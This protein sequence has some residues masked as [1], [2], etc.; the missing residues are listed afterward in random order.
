[1][2][3]TELADVARRSGLNVIETPGWKTRGHG[4]MAGVKTIICHHTA[5]PKTGEMPSLNTV[6]AGRPGLPGP[7]AQLGLGRSGAV[8]VVA[9]GLSYHAGA[10]FTAEQGNVNAIGIEAEATGID[11]W[12][13]VQYD[14]YAR[15][16]R[17]LIDHYA[18]PLFKVLG[19]KEVATPLGRKVD[20]NFDMGEF[21]MAVSQAGGP[22]LDARQA[23]QLN[24]VLAQLTGSPEP[25]Q[26]PG[27][28]TWAGGSQEQ[29]TLVDYLRRANVEVRQAW[30]EIHAAR[31]ALAKVQT[32]GV[33]V[34]ALAHKVADVIAARLK[35]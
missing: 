35:D 17:T 16:C 33:D 1:M 26:Y 22:D 3:L 32:G 27:W 14:A 10:T 31:E 4:G 21:R 6:V 8:Y 13:A 2:W 7:L 11:A 18:L 25:G 29:M 5:G 20:P 28:P 12:P 15:L 23:E 30:L 9:A 24:Q 19:H 34:D